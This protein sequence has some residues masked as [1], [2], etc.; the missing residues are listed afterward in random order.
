MKLM[1]RAEDREH[2]LRDRRMRRGMYVLPSLF[3]MGNI[4]LGYYAITQALQGSA[5]QP[6]HFRYSAIAIGFAT[7]FDMLDGL[8]ARMTK[9]ESEFGKEL[10][11]LADVITFGVAPAILAYAWGF[12]NLPWLE[13]PALQTMQTKII[14]AGAVATFLFLIAGASRLAR[15]NISKNP[16]PSNPGRPGGKYFVGMPIP[17]GAGVI[18]SVVYA[19]DGAAIFNWWLALC[20]MAM[21]IFVGFLMVSRWR[22]F[23]LKGLDLHLRKPFRALFV[24]AVICTVI[25]LISQIALLGLAV[26][27][28]ISG[29]LSRASY[30]VTRRHAPAAPSP[31]SSLEPAKESSNPD[32]RP[33][34]A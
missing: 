29:I 24:I 14:Q 20:W 1:R 3:T 13:N 22:F 33:G 17:A 25:V 6:L 32:S 5:E 10:D 11:S 12:R 7:V 16:Q 30:F 31:D 26:G 19:V 34:M 8:V 27:Y 15:F 18:A 21:V 2:A 4:G 23:S 28:M 9:T